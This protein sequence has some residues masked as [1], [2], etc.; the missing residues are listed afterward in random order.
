MSRKNAVLVIEDDI[1][2]G[3]M[4]RDAISHLGYETYLAY[5]ATGGLDLIRQKHLDLVITDMSLP[6]MSGIQ[7][8]E[9]MMGMYLNIPIILMT[10]AGDLSGIRE[11]LEKGVCDYL[12]K[13]L[14]LEELSIVIA[15]NLSRNH[16][17]LRDFQNDKAEILFKAL[18]ALMRALDAKDHYTCGHSQRWP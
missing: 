3:E 14:N 8:S 12:I 6:G 4:L 11:A 9:K 10:N 17:S 2:Y 18:K 7:L 13:P 16:N 1:Q 5:S 15:K